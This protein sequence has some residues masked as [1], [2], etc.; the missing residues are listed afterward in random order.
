MTLFT[1]PKPE[2]ELKGLVFGLTELEP[3]RHF[4]FFRRP[5]TWAAAVGIAFLALNL[6]FR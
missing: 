3:Q 2:S 6:W 5:I 1:K 4:S